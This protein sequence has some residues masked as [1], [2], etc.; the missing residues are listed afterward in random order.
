MGSRE[1]EWAQAMRAERRGDAAAYRLLL[2]QIAEAMRALMRRRLSRL[3]LSV[4]ETED[5]VQEVLIAVHEKRGQWDESRPFMP[6]LNAIA[7]YKLIDNARRLRREA[8]GRVDL[9]ERDWERMFEPAQDTDRSPLD[10]ERLVSSLPQG[11]QSV[12]RALGIDGASVRETAER[13]KT[14]EGAIRVALHRAL[15]RLSAGARQAD[16]E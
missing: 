12:V 9:D 14:S 16:G 10:V 6:W 1:L 11:Q 5:V 2:R 3:G 7:R 4:A 13:M 15:K 8:T